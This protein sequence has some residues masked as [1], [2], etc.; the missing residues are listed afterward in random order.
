MDFENLTT[1]QLIELALNE[2]DDAT[3]W[4]YVVILHRRGGKEVFEAAKKLC[5]SG[6]STQI[7]LGADILGQLGTLDLP[8]RRQSVPI[9]LRISK[10][11]KDVNVL[12][13]VTMALGRMKDEKVINRLLELKNHTNEDIRFAVVHGLLGLEEEPAIQALLE[14]SSDEDEDLRNWATFGLGSL[15]DTDSE[16]IREA[17]FQRFNE[18]DHEIRGEAMVGLARRKDER[19]VELLLKELSGEEIGLLPVEAAYEIGDIRL[20]EVL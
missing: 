4:N 7:T 20:C 13:A 17:L 10:K 18:I 1:N 2:K 16:E 12:Q 11:E 3:R 9:L 6:I 14:L 5:E 19:V 15:I 8:Y